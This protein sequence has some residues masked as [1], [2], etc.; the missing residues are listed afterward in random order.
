MASQAMRHIRTLLL[1]FLM[2]LAPFTAIPA[3]ADTPPEPLGPF[4]LGTFD[5]EDWGALALQ[6]IEQKPSLF[7]VDALSLQL[8]VAGG[9]NLTDPAPRLGLALGAR[10]DL[11]GTSLH[12]GGLFYWDQG[13][14]LRLGLYIGFD[15]SP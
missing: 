13:K 3:R 2:L 7:G 15:F 1:T 14:P 8:S 5:G 4:F 10:Y 9:Y 6:P 12:G 11:Q